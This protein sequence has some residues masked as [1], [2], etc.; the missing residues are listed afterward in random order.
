MTI[1][2]IKGCF[3]T[4]RLSNWLEY[5]AHFEQIYENK[6]SERNFIAVIFKVFYLLQSKFFFLM[7]LLCRFHTFR[8]FSISRKSGCIAFCM[9]RRD[10][11]YNR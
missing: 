8:T 2:D 9:E 1:N 3:A 5:F 4:I 11:S 10:A 6:D 7:K